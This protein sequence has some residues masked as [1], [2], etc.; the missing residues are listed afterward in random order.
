LTVLTWNVQDPVRQRR[1]SLVGFTQLSV[2]LAADQR[3]K[4]LSSGCGSE[5]SALPTGAV[6]L[7]FFL[8]V[9]IYGLFTPMH[10]TSFL[11]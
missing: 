2:I 11:V 6:L 3:A 9:D 5:Q 4:M 8:S 10:H 1:R 7:C